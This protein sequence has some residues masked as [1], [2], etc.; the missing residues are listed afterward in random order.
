MYRGVHSS[1]IEAKIEIDS[2][3]PSVKQRP[4][5]YRGV[6]LR[7]SLESEKYGE[8]CGHE[9]DKIIDELLTNPA[10]TWLGASGIVS[11]LGMA[12]PTLRDMMWTWNLHKLRFVQIA[13][14]TPEGDPEIR[15]IAGSSAIRC[16]RRYRLFVDSGGCQLPVDP[17]ILYRRLYP[18]KTRRLDSQLSNWSDF[19]HV[20]T[21]AGAV[22]KG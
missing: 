8:L 22:R 17:A 4:P 16:W 21:G 7:Q 6:K 3:N 18:G 19:R 2:M 15:K 11:F 9:L 1:F 14:D 5:W 13:A 20:E 12:Y 10:F